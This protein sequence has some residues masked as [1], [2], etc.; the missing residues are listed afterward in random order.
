M[1]R[2]V[3]AEPDE[4]LTSW[5]NEALAPVPEF[6][7]VG[8]ATEGEGA[9]DVIRRTRPDVAVVDADLVMPAPDGRTLVT[10]ILDAAPATWVVVLA[11]DVSGEAAHAALAAGAAGVLAK[12][13]SAEMLAELWSGP[14]PGSEA[15]NL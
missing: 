5:L 3:F 1:L 15:T 4:S 9:L 12:N 14:G 6:E 7:V 11:E 8:T 13:G 2:V 10:A